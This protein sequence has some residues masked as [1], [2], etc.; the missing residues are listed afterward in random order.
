MSEQYSSGTKNPKQTN[1]L[2]L[3]TRSGLL[4]ITLINQ[5][6]KTR[7]IRHNKIQGSTMHSDNMHVPTQN[8]L[9]A[10]GHQES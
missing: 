2:G 10:V 8:F 5:Y 7:R 1:V 6:G 3:Q 9:R 4:T